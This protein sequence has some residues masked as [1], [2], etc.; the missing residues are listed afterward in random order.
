MYLLLF[1]FKQKTAYEMRISDWSSDLCSSDLDLR[2][3]RLVGDDVGA[4]LAQADI[5]E[6]AGA[7]DSLRLGADLEQVDR[8]G[9]HPLRLDRPRRQR[10]PQRSPQQDQPYADPFEDAD[11]DHRPQP[12]IGGQIVPPAAGQPVV[13]PLIEIGKDRK[14]GVKGTR[15]SVGVDFGGR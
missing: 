9:A 12:L 1:F 5:E 11:R 7:P 10:E 6:D 2:G 3:D 4:V 15:V 8:A 14:S 13:E